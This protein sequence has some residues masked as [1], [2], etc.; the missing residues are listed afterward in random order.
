MRPLI[1]MGM[2][3]NSDY[4][5]EAKAIAVGLSE[6][7]RLRRA[8]P[9]EATGML[10]LEMV[11]LYLMARE[12]RS[13]LIVELG[14]YLGGS[15]IALALGALGSGR[16]AIV[17]AVDDHEWHRHVA[18]NVSREAIARLPST[19]PLF[20]RNLESAG[21]SDTVRVLVS[22]TAA[23][24]L[25]V[26]EDVSLLLIDAG[27]DERSLRAD[28][29]AWLPKLSSGAIVGFHDYGNR[30]WPDVKRVVDE[31]RECFASF[32]TH[33]TLALARIS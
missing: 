25:R 3:L 28:V 11:L 13:G 5:V 23:A 14:S 22:D 21:V 33:Q 15:T 6:I 9:V 18:G 29:R 19:L 10:E 1:D 24:A 27:H 2:L 17:L 7:R 8:I 20:E 12:T 4:R 30:A 31:E 26:S 32:S 16:E